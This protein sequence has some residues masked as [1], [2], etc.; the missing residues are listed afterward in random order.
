[1]RSV[2]MLTTRNRLAFY[3]ALKKEIMVNPLET[4][5][6]CFQSD[7]SEFGDREGKK[8]RVVNRNESYVPPLCVGVCG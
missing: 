5:P 1:M 8:A 2:Y 3:I 7:R 6:P 4:I